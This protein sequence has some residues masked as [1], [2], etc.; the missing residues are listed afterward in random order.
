MLG[1]NLTRSLLGAKKITRQKNGPF[2]GIEDLR[3]LGAFMIRTGGVGNT[4][5][6]VA[7]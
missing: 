7:Y 1:H 4:P 6:L 5:L 2:K 3:Q